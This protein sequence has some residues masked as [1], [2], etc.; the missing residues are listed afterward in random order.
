MTSSTE[1]NTT[2]LSTLSTL[3]FPLYFYFTCM[4]AFSCVPHVCSALRGGKRTL[5]A[6]KLE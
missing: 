2:L 1:N 3:P 5:D 4:G 6:L